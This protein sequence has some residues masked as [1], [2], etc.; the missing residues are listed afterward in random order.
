MMRLAWL[1]FSLLG[2]LSAAEK[3]EV[4]L[5]VPCGR[6]SGRPVKDPDGAG[7]VCLDRTPF[8]T[9]KDVESAETHR[10]SAGNYAVFLTFHMEAAQRELQVTLK[11]VGGRVAIVFNGT[12]VS[13]PR[14]S[15][16]SRFLFIDGKYDHGHAAGIVEEFNKQSRR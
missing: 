9:E 2:A 15:S 16:G 10:T 4:H 1:F 8:L 11:N 3:L 13:A 6:D 7:M 5:V 14:I 12:L